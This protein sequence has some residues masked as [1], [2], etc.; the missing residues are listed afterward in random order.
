MRTLFLLV[1]KFYLVDFIV[2]SY[3]F[4]RQLSIQYANKSIMKINKLICYS[5]DCLITTSIISWYKSKRWYADNNTDSAFN[6]M[7][8]PVSKLSECHNWGEEFSDN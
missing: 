3:R 1:E 8:S 4:Y 7:I 5:L 6:A 2:L